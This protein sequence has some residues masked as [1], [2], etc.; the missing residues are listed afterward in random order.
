[1]ARLEPFHPPQDRDG[2]PALHVL[3]QEFTAPDG[4]RRTRTGLVGLLSTGAG[5]LRPLERAPARH[6]AA[7]PDAP[8]APVLALHADPAGAVR[9]VLVQVAGGRPWSDVTDEAGVRH[10]L[11]RVAGPA[12]ADALARAVAALP[13]LLVA[14]GHE[15]LARARDR[16][17]PHVLACLVALD[18][19]GLALLPVHRLV[20]GRDQPAY[21]ALAQALRAG[22][23]IEEVGLGDLTPTGDDAHATF[24]YLD[25]HFRRGFRLR[26]RAASGPAEVDA[27]VLERDLL[28]GPLGFTEAELD[29]QTGLAYA[30]SAEEAVEL[31]L[32]GA[33]DL[34]FLLRA[35]TAARLRG[36][37]ETGAALPPATAAFVPPFPPEFSPTGPAAGG[38]IGA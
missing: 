1:M 34:A 12:A 16:G 22:Y 32:R 10:R 31:V 21:E 36:A 9:A 35:P 25:A 38:S 28:R 37:A 7:P 4:G 13:E 18:D 30:H 26:R 24:G 6:G 20:A 23:A 29:E 14:E 27:A 11:H 17:D 8:A 2:G 19:P 15:T 3:A 33:H 5:A